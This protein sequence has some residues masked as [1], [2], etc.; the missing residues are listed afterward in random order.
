MPDRYQTLLKLVC[1]TLAIVVGIQ[2]LQLMRRTDPLSGLT[3][4][5]AASTGAAS[6]QQSN[7]QSLQRS[8]V[9]PAV[10]ARVDR[11]TQSEILGAVVR[12][13]PIALIGIGGTDAFIRTTSGQTILLREGEES[14]GIKLLRLGTNRVVIEH[15][16]QTKELML[17]SGLGSTTLLPQEKK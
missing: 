2:I 14:N 1:L 12:P 9:A 3:T 10:Q 7:T 5:A 16:S 15:E 4:I 11:I 17:F 6:L 8:N 13:Q